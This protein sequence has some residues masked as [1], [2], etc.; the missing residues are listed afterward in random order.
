MAILAPG[1]LHRD[2][3]ETMLLSSGD[4][5]LLDAIE[6]LTEHGKRFEL[7]V[8]S[9]GVSTDLQARANRIYWINDFASDVRRDPRS[10]S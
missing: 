7:A 8:F 2:R 3:Y 1:T 4:G 10:T 5:H 9:E 6:F